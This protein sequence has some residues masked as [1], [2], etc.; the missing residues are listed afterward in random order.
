MLGED[1][2]DTGARKAHQ[3]LRNSRYFRRRLKQMG[4]LV[5]GHED[6]PVVPLMT[7]FIPKVVEFSRQTL[8]YDIGL[9]AVGFPATPLT[10]ARVRFCLSADHTKEQLDHVLDVVDKVG[11]MTGTKYGVK[12]CVGTMIEY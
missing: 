3:L 5:Y 2:T 7:F 11:D 12:E 6:S 4:F 1:G 10:K 9:V 8:K